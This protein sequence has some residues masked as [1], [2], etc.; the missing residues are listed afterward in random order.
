L[1]RRDRKKR[2][3]RDQCQSLPHSFSIPFTLLQF[4]V[5]LPIFHYGKKKIEDKSP[6]RPDGRND[7]AKP[8][9]ALGA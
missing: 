1:G 5:L 8:A 3:R 9:M 7:A 2:K 4:S 6:A